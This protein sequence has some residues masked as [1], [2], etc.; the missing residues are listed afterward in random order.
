MHFL[1]IWQTYLTGITKKVLT[2]VEKQEQT[3][4][5]EAKYQY[6]EGSWFVILNIDQ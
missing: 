6:S 5:L 4:F 2:N 1:Y 3:A